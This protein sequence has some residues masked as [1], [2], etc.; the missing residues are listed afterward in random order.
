MEKLPPESL[1]FGL[2]GNTVEQ[3][4]NAVFLRDGLRYA[5]SAVFLEDLINRISMD[6]AAVKH[7]GTEDAVECP[8]HFGNFK[9][10]QSQYAAYISYFDL[11]LKSIGGITDDL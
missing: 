10:P 4:F 2:V 1:R 8:L 9:L 7:A 11:N 6:M 3:I 5:V